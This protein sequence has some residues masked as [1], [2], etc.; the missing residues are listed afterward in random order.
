MSARRPVRARTTHLPSGAARR[1]PVVVALLAALAPSALAAQGPFSSLTFFGDSYSDTGNAFLLTG[2]TQPPS[3]PY[4]LGRFS[5]GPVYVDYL[6]A[7]L[8]RPGD[9]APAFVTRAARGNYAVAAARTQDIP[10]L[11]IGTQTQVG[12]YLTRP[13]AAPGARTDPTGLY[14]LFAGG[15]DLRDAGTLS[16]ATARQVAATAAAS[17]VVE[18][19]GLLAASGAGTVMVF[20]LGGLGAAPEAL[21]IPGR[22][23]VLD[24]LT[25]T[26]NR[27]LAEGVAGLQL[28][29][30]GTTFLNFRLDNLFA[31]VLRD[32]RTGGRRYGLTNG[33]TPC[34][35]PFAPPGAPSC[36]VSLFADDLHPTTRAHQLVADA[37]FTY[38][39]TGRN[40]A[41]IPEPATL[42]LVAAGLAVTGVAARRRTGGTSRGS[43][44]HVAGCEQAER[45]EL[46][47]ERPHR[48]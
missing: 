2:G 6:A 46:A 12:A 40:V 25:G 15:N 10:G 34:L 19:A 41:V 18:Q 11:P 20:S 9:A 28:A 42:A 1:F 44:E 30:P 16:D 26:F 24:A 13:G 7:R 39:T 27:T 23:S 17:R 31:N 5:N 33:T 37:A 29:L 45:I 35:S 8:G 43:R 48:A 21:A 3:P 32:A 38:V 4:A 22:P 36:D 47:L 14:T